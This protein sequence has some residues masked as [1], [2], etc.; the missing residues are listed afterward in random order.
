MALILAAATFNNSAPL[1]K[2]LPPLPVRTLCPL[3]HQAM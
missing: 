1:C 2:A 3:S